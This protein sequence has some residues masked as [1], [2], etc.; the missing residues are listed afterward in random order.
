MLPSN[1]EVRINGIF[2][3]GLAPRPPCPPAAGDGEALRRVAHMLRFFGRRGYTQSEDW[4]PHTPAVP[5]P[6]P[7]DNTTR[8]VFASRWPLPSGTL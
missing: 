3:H 1:I 7:G 5:A 6:P 2:Q 4:E 8:T